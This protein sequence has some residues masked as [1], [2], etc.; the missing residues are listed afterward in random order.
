[1]SRIGFLLLLLLSAPALAQVGLP[2]SAYYNSLHD[3]YKSYIVRTY[4]DPQRLAWLLADTAIDHWSCSPDA[5]D[6]SAESYSYRVASA[7]GR[8]IV[9][10]TAQFG[11]EAMLHEDSRYRPSGSRN[12]GRRI[13]FAFRSSVTAYHPDGSVGPAY[14]RISAS[15]VA[16]ATSSTWHPQ[17]MNAS[18]LLASIGQS[19][20]DRAG[21][22]LLTE[23]TPEL[24]A[25]G[26][27]AWNRLKK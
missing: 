22:N 13:L 14:G 25:F 15:L 8:R 5:W 20:L 16:R 21:N 2:A 10:N 23:F 26:A 17:Q 19:A 6:R 12:F 18:I 4:T 3:R 24:K 27:A 11:F 9:A 1:M 7:W